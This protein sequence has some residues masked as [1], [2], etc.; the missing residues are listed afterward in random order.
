MSRT[1]DSDVLSV[2]YSTKLKIL[3]LCTEPEGEGAPGQD[4]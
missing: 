3:H 4:V 1:L 2:S